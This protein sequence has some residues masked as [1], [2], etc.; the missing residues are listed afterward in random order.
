VK[1]IVS[2]IDKLFFRLDLINALE[3]WDI[4]E[5]ADKC[6]LTNHG[7]SFFQGEKRVYVFLSNIFELTDRRFKTLESYRNWLIENKKE[8]KQKEIPDEQ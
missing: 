4:Y 2:D 1:A 3:S 5:F 8:L 6:G 7:D